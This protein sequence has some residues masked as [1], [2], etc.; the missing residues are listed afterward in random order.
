[1]IKERFSIALLCKD[2]LK[3]VV[4]SFLIVLCICSCIEHG[5]LFSPN[6]PI[7]LTNQNVI[8]LYAV[9]LTLTPF[10]MLY[11]AVR[12]GYKEIVH[13]KEV[14]VLEQRIPKAKRMPTIKRI[15]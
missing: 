6:E 14:P 5:W 8:D 2:L 13:Y 11:K 12:G 1:M 3:M 15:K 10:L 7:H 4:Q 9:C